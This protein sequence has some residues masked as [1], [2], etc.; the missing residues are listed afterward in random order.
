M[1]S[2]MRLPPKSRSMTRRM[3]S[4]SWNPMLPMVLVGVCGL[5]YNGVDSEEWLVGPE[6]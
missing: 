4:S 3:R 2:G 6:G 1:S 5:Y